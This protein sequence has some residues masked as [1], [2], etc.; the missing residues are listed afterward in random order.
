[1]ALSAVNE[2]IRR[3]QRRSQQLRP[4]TLIYGVNQIAC[5]PGNID[6]FERLGN[7]GFRGYQHAF[8]SML[9]SDIPTGLTFKRDTDISI[10]NDETGEV[11][12][13]KVGENNSS[14]TMVIILNLESPTT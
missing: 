12:V 4:C 11:F 14:Q 10:R 1:M 3:G 6:F 7:G 2:L 9:R 5:T 13:L 8:V